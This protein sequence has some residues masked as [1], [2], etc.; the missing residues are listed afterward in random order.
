MLSNSK[1]VLGKSRYFYNFLY[2]ICFDFVQL[3][4]LIFYLKQGLI[5]AFTFEDLTCRI[6]IPLIVEMQLKIEYMCFFGLLFY[7]RLNKRRKNN[8]GEM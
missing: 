8:F 5:D 6:H 4:K 2:E 1:I 3:M 7:V